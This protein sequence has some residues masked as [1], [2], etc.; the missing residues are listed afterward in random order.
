MT[1]VD[2]L[3]S[4]TPVFILHENNYATRAVTLSAKELGMMS[5]NNLRETTLGIRPVWKI[6]SLTLHS[7]LFK[8]FNTI[9]LAIFNSETLLVNH[10]SQYMVGAHAGC[11][12]I[13]VLVSPLYDSSEWILN[14][15]LVELDT[16]EDL[17]AS[18]N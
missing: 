6:N 1:R 7:L 12:G 17:S 16:I 18:Y 3:S 15:E 10:L 9:R 14:V 5:K 11:R 8:Y 2:S 4:F 13:F